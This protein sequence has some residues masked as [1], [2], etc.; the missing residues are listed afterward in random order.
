M[1]ARLKTKTVFVITFFIVLLAR[2]RTA[3]LQYFSVNEHARRRAWVIC[4]R[5]TVAM[6]LG[7]LTGEFRSRL[8]AREKP[9]GTAGAG[10]V[11]VAA[12]LCPDA[13]SAESVGEFIRFGELS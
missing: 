4:P 2:C 13:S 1:H 12:V 5:P 6:R 10:A 11:R 9:E 7:N 3:A 8:I